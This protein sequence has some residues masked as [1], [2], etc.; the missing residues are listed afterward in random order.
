MF[1]QASIAAGYY[2]FTMNIDCS[3]IQ[4]ALFIGC[5]HP[6]TEP[7]LTQGLAGRA[8]TMKS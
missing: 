5:D 7:V 8:R 3:T 4:M 1:A 2:A 6:L